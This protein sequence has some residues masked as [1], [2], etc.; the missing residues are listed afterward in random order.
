[1][2]I[3]ALVRPQVIGHFFRVRF[4]SLDGRNEVRAVYGGFGVAMA[5]VL[6]LAAPK[7]PSARSRAVK[8][9]GG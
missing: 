3:T 8:Q 6:I 9:E 5:A 1:M 2:G 4:D 7:A